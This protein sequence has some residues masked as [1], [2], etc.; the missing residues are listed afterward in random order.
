MSHTKKIL[1]RTP[2]SRAIVNEKLLKCD[3]TFNLISS[4]LRSIEDRGVDD[5]TI[6]KC[7]L[8]A[9]FHVAMFS[10][11]YFEWNTRRMYNE[12]IMRDQATFKIPST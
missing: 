6:E 12:P 11:E 4:Y 3:Y 5:V 2:C 7:F 10:P 8:F 1:L 9:T